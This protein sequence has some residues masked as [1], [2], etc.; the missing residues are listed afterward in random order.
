MTKKDY[1]RIAQVF[2]IHLDILSISPENP[3]LVSYGIEELKSLASS[4]AG[5][6]QNDNPRFDHGRF[7]AACGIQGSN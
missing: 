1:I 2:K 5:M 7:I 6:L 3:F 4:I